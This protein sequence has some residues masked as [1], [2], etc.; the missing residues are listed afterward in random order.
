MFGSLLTRISNLFSSSPAIEV[1][2]PRLLP[3][4]SYISI[5][6]QQSVATVC[7]TIRPYKPGQ[8]EYQ[9]T[10]WTAMCCQNVTLK[11]NDLVRV[12]DRQGLVLIVE[13]LHYAQY[14]WN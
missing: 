1:D 14:S 2:L 3:S 10:P 4:P 8:V 13:P 7:A 6:E 9:G 12:I 11:E 5:Q